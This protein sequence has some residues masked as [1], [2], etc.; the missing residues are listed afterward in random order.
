MKDSKFDLQNGNRSPARS[1]SPF[2]EYKI[3][4]SSFKDDLPF[5]KTTS[6]NGSDKAETTAKSMSQKE[7]DEKIAELD[8][9]LKLIS[10]INFK[11]EMEKQ[12]LDSKK[13]NLENR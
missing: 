12:E 10:E 1:G 6:S 13:S 5:T 4:K 9:R 8:T 7:K 2:D 3:T 11:L